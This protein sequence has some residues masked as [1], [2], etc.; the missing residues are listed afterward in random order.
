MDFNAIADALE[1]IAETVPG[2][3]GFA[4]VPDSLPTIAFVVGEMDVNLNITMRGKR[5]PG[6]PRRGSDEANITCRILVARFEDKFALKKLREFM[7]GH[8]ATSIIDAI[9]QNRTLNGTVDD[10]VVRTMRG[11]RLFVVGESRYYGV[12]LDLYVIGD[13]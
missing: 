1:T 7:G 8:G 3:N 5:T 6:G 9:E 11:N 4:S 12:E 13:A 2:I 10:S